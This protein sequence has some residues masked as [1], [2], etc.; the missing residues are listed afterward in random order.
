MTLTAF[1]FGLAPIRRCG[2]LKY[3][4][5]TIYSMIAAVLLIYSAVQSFLGKFNLENITNL[6]RPLIIVKNVAFLYI[7]SSNVNAYYVVSFFY[8]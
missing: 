6:I 1:V 8:Y 3:I 7:L 5:Y 2:E 4:V